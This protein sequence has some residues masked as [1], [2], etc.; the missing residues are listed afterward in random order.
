MTAHGSQLQ[1][2]SA[3]LRTAAIAVREVSRE[4]R[5][6]S[7]EIDG[8]TSGVADAIAG[9]GSAAA[10]GEFAAGWKGSFRLKLEQLNELGDKLEMAADGYDGSDNS[11]AKRLASL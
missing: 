6:T 4:A 8:I 10:V 9:S 5:T 11:A 3:A 1:V 7:D 2:A